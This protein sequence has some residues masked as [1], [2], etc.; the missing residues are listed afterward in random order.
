MSFLDPRWQ[1][2]REHWRA[3]LG[4]LPLDHPSFQRTSRVWRV[5]LLPSFHSDVAITVTD[6]DV[7]G[8]L[9]LRVADPALRGYAMTAAGIAGGTTSHATPPSPRVW[10]STVTAEALERLSRAMPRLPLHSLPPAGRDGITVEC[11]ALIHGERF[12]FDA[13]CPTLSRAPLHHGFAVGLCT[14]A[15]QVIADPAGRAALDA[16]APYLR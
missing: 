6:L 1:S 13:W 15:W 9:E 16:T 5:T 4:L 8:W 3:S 2:Y 11:E 10:E 7:G 14:L 12:A